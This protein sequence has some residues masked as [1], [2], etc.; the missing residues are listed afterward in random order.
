MGDRIVVMKDGLVQQVDTPLGL[1]NHPA[2]MF[3]A[4]FIGTPSMN[5]LD[6]KIVNG[7]EGYT[8]DGGC[9]KVK[10]PAEK[11]ELLKPY[12]DKDVVFG[13]RPEDIFD[14]NLSNL[15]QATP[16]NV[17]H[18]MVDV[19]EPMGPIVTMYLSCGGHSM[20]ATIDAET[21]AKELEDIELVFDMAKTH[22]FDKETEKAVY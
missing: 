1:Y 3:V 21:K 9:F 2:N 8:I 18:A 16:D 12:V 6:A 22:V 10:A 14:K 17:A 4:G 19:I 13:V 11:A 20:V 7:S 15:L 5:F